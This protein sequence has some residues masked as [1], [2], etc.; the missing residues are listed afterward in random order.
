MNN[1]ILFVRFVDQKIS[2][3]AVLSLLYFGANLHKW[4]NHTTSDHGPG[5]MLGV[6]WQ[7][8]SSLT[9]GIS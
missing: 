1:K 4:N 7:N 2:V 3:K 6:H 5:P 9:M 8:G